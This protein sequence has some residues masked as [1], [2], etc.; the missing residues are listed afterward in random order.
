ME[1]FLS[2][3][4]Q[5]LHQSPSEVVI[6]ASVWIDVLSSNDVTFLLSRNIAV[7]VV[8][9]SYLAADQE[10][11]SSFLLNVGSALREIRIINCSQEISSTIVQF[12]S[13]KGNQINFVFQSLPWFND[14]W[15]EAIAKRFHNVLS[16]LSLVSCSITNQG[17]FQLSKRCRKLS[18]FTLVSCNSV[19]DIGLVEVLRNN[20]LSNV[21]IQ[22]SNS[23]SDIS[24]ETLSQNSPNLLEVSIINVQKI[25]NESISFLHEARI[26]M[27][28]RKVH[29]SQKLYKLQLSELGHLNSEIFLWICASMRNIIEIDL[30]SC[31][32]L[33]FSMAFNELKHLSKLNKMIIGPS[34]V[35]FQPNEQ[36]LDD[37][38]TVF[39]QLS[40][41]CVRGIIGLLDS[42]LSFVLDH[43]EDNFE[44]IELVDIACSTQFIESLCTSQSKLL[45]ISICRSTLI[46]DKDL[47]CLTSA[48]ISIESLIVENC[49]KISESAF[50]RLGNLRKLQEFIFQASNLTVTSEVMKYLVRAPLK[51]L[52]LKGL[53]FQD[54]SGFLTLLPKT[55]RT[56]QKISLQNSVLLHNNDFASN[57]L[58]R[59]LLCE[60]VD[61]TNCEISNIDSLQQLELQNPF[62]SFEFSP[63][64]WGYRVLDSKRFN[65]HRGLRIVFHRH[66]MA[67]VI[68]H[69][70]RKWMTRISDLR[71]RRRDNWKDLKVFCVTRI[72]AAW[73]RVRA[74]KQFQKAK[75]AARLITSCI[76]AV[77][78]KKLRKKIM[79]AKSY[80]KFHILKQSFRKVVVSVEETKKADQI[81]H[82]L[83][84]QLREMHLLRRAFVD[85]LSRGDLSRELR[86]ME[87]ASVVREIRLLK[88]VLKN[89]QSCLYGRKDERLIFC[90]KLLTILPLR[91]WNSTRQV[92]MISSARSIYERRLLLNC[93][94]IMAEAHNEKRRI[95]LLIPIAV[96]HFSKSFFSRVIF[97]VFHAWAKY[98]I[99]KEAIQKRREQ[100]GKFFMRKQAR[101]ALASW[102][103]YSDLRM[104]LKA[105]IQNSKEYWRSKN[106]KDSKSAWEIFASRMIYLK[107]TRLKA[108]GSHRRW[109]LEQGLIDCYRGISSMRNWKR[110][111]TKAELFCRGQIK[112]RSFAAWAIFK[113]FS[114]NLEQYYFRRYLNKQKKKILRILTFNTRFR[115]E[116]KRRLLQFINDNAASPEHCLRGIVL[117]QAKVR[118]H[119]VLRRFKENRVQKLYAIQV[120]QNFFRTLLARKDFGKRIK[121]QSLE[122]TIREDHELEAMRDAEVETR[123]FLYQL[124]AIVTI[125]RCFRGWKG[126][127]IFFNRAV[128]FY[129]DKSIEYYK[130]NHHMHQYHEMYLRAAIAREQLRHRSATII[131]KI[132]RGMICRRRFVGVKHQAR[133]ESLA[134]VV[135]CAYRARLAKLKFTAMKRN[136]T[137]ENRF[138]AARKQRGQVLRL[139]GFK[140]RRMQNL[141]APIL[142]G[143]GID[144]ITFNYRI[145]ELIDETVQ[146]Y[147][148]L[149]NILRR[150]RA[151]VREHGVNRLNLAMGRRKVL[152]TQGW[153]YQ[154]QDAVKIVEPGHNF[155]GYTGTI[156]RIDESLLGVPLYEVK[157]DKFPRQTYVRMTADPLQAYLR[158][159]P[160][161]KITKNP[162]ISSTSLALADEMSP[163]LPTKRNNKAA[164]K[165]QNCFRK[166]RSRSI[167][168]RRRYEHWL[169]NIDR[170]RS[171]LSHFSESNT[172]SS[173]GNLV[174]KVLGLKSRKEI[175]FDEMRHKIQPGRLRA[176]VAKKNEASVI[177]REFDLKMK[178]RTKF[179]Q[180][181]ALIQAKDYFPL[182]Y[183]RLTMSRKLMFAV[184]HGYGMFFKSGKSLRDGTGSRSTKIISRKESIVT[185]LDRY[186][187][188]QFAN[189]PHVRYHKTFLYQGEWSGV[190]FFTSVI[191]HGEG[192]IVFFDGWGFAREDK[193]LYLT[194]VRCRYL[195]AMDLTTSDP[196]CD[197]YCNGI[198]LQTSIKWENLNPEFHESFEIDVTNPA[199]ELN[200]VVK[201]KDYFGSDDFMGQVVIPLK[202]YNDGKEH[203]LILQLKGEDPN[204]EEDFD[205]GEIEL[206][207]RWAE[208]LFEDDQQ[209]LE[210]KGKMLIRIQAWARRIA[211]LIKLKKLRAEYVKNYHYIR[212]CAVKITCVCRMRLS[213]KEFKRLSRNLK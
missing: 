26:K 12:V 176:T 145:G 91:Y 23:I 1:R 83:G 136:I 54:F 36:T 114:A 128:E 55:I 201:D 183:E 75:I 139:F 120:L 20:C 168:A 84:S 46:S 153:K 122:E 6:N 186:Q 212:L 66:S 63:E 177:G 68:Q 102:R 106:L 50:T 32:Q 194:I 67:R 17:L 193:V 111:N 157:L 30:S 156:V 2:E 118:M 53:I 141:V 78:M 82:V 60:C 51:R 109:I 188:S 213:I 72:Q 203:T 210:V 113:K 190:P 85:L 134:I 131:Q 187:F 88:N 108:D 117:L 158:F 202:A 92:K 94:N 189:S 147:T 47:R 142:R 206:R 62:L 13:N 161:A 124:G 126:R 57:I 169:Q 49:P 70:I 14:K 37:M 41:V 200:V 197:V 10:C 39:S 185:G 103:Q 79:L 90:I 61:L 3:S 71:R 130:E 7:T 40:V 191:P 4:F 24:I 69:L 34:N 160:L 182:G 81:L 58:N 140:T 38:S 205:R 100:A 104:W 170:H 163:F 59:Y 155:E 89:W 45:Q 43:T 29:P 33:D 42:H 171:F 73:R 96:E 181:A 204:F 135:Q 209:R 192:L 18:K 48:C 146:D 144:P 99:E 101:N 110:M 173:H 116:E 64:F 195:N 107:G 174:A 115:L 148:Q 179:L 35:P 52:E 165:I 9:E 19:T 211:A 167:V 15:L 28:N 154:I 22:H 198:N 175:Y 166:F 11:L 80:R 119:K 44:R 159:Q 138:S 21:A 31:S 86:Y 74:K 164:T 132:A 207:L 162:V 123:F 180:K 97:K 93:W 149:T 208:R 172:L 87:S 127:I 25:S 199:A 184:R 112:G 76:L 178:D 105:R 151:L 121:L 5:L 65:L 150:E 196:Y 77:A 98:K 27:G 152:L 137:N 8:F 133:V 129:R 56:L 95:N 125:Q 16:G 143:F